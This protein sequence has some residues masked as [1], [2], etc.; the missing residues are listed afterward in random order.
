MS[1]LPRGRWAGIVARPGVE[2]EDL[3]PAGWC[4][5]ARATRRCSRRRSSPPARGRPGAT[6]HARDS[7]PALQPQVACRASSTAGGPGTVRCLLRGRVGLEPTPPPRR[8]RVRALGGAPPSELHRPIVPG[9]GPGP[10]ESLG[11]SPRPRGSAPAGSDLAR[12]VADGGE[13]PAQCLGCS[14]GG[15]CDV[16]RPGGSPGLT[17][18]RWF[19]LRV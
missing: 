7:T 8:T 4:S 17:G 9:P 15:Q 3:H 1:P 11:R 14:P 18:V 5:T 2:P 6:R 12:Q 13:P 19:R 16:A 10:R